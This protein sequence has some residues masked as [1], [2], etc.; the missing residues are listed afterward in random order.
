MRLLPPPNSSHGV[1]TARGDAGV[2]VR[3]VDVLGREVA[4][5]GEAEL[6]ARP[7]GLASGAYAVRLLL[8]AGGR[9]ER[10]AVGR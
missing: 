2:C 4:V 9:A 7:P 6:P 3:V 5:L 10:F 1:S 8:G